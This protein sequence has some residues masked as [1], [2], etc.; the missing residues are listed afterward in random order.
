MVQRLEPLGLTILINTTIQK[1]KINNPIQQEYTQT[2]WWVRIRQTSSVRT[3]TLTW[4]LIKKTWLYATMY[5]S[6][7]EWMPFWYGTRRRPIYIQR[8]PSCDAIRCES[9]VHRIWHVGSHPAV[10]CSY[11]RLPTRML[12]FHL[13]IWKRLGRGK[14]RETCSR[15]TAMQ[16]AWLMT[17][18]NQTWWGITWAR[19][20]CRHVSGVQGWNGWVA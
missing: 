6:S 12:Y 3:R 13:A 2:W 20:I 8:N 7:R 14:W 15:L 9:E 1:I 19:Y 5:K 10:V 18:A 16:W 11:S 4:I 17:R